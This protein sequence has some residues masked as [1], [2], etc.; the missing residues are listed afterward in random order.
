MIK[1]DFSVAWSVSVVGNDWENNYNGHVTDRACKHWDG[2]TWL[3]LC[4]DCRNHCCLRSKQAYWSLRG[5]SGRMKGIIT[6]GSIGVL[7]RSSTV[8]QI[9]SPLTLPLLSLLFRFR[10]Q[11]FWADIEKRILF[12][13]TLLSQRVD[14][15]GKESSGLTP[16]KGS[17]ESPGWGEK[18]E[19]AVVCLQTYT[20]VLLCP[21]ILWVHSVL[22]DSELIL[23]RRT[24]CR[25][26]SHWATA[27]WQGNIWSS[28]C[29]RWAQR[30]GDRFQPTFAWSENLTIPFQLLNFISNIKGWRKTQRRCENCVTSLTTV[31]PLGWW[32][33]GEEITNSPRALALRIIM[34]P[35][36]NQTSSNS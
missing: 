31:P 25:A 15:Q 27:G 14:T 33:D 3:N 4:L 36:V 10:F 7:I 11:I 18:V 24:Q 13:F 26:S 5:K 35:F 21:V 1:L 34:C 8:T 20:W 17:P 29:S 2:S 19:W 23:A 32:L 12:S 28:I 30:N 9:T 6:S 16:V 22:M